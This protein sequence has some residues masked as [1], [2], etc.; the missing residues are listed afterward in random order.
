MLRLAGELADGVIVTGCRAMEV[1]DRRLE[2]LREAAQG[3]GREPAAVDVWAMTYVSIADTREKAVADVAPY[4]AVMGGLWLRKP[5]ARALVPAELDEA[6]STMIEHY[7]PAEHVVVGSPQ[8]KLVQELDLADF[9]ADTTAV[10]GTPDEVRATL[11]GFQERGMS[12][13]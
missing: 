9:L 8:A 10:V 11:R 13:L 6:A 7:N 2:V 5:Y 1:V 4:L 3:A 12:A